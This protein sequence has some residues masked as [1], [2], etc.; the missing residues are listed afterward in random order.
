MNRS[1]EWRRES[2]GPFYLLQH[3][4]NR[5]LEEYLQP[6]RSRGKEAPPTD[7]DPT[8]WN[9]LIDVYETPEEI[10][11]V[12]EI[13]GVNPAAVD[14]AVTGNVMTLRGVKETADLPEPAV[15][16]RERRL[17]SFN[18][19]ITLP[20]QVDFDRAHAEANHGVLKVRLPKRTAAKPRTIPIRPG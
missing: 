18:R 2:S 12:A 19:Q 6:A 15:L 16:L 14:L 4:L 1:S 11:V 9:P 20:D 7:I 8:S 5:L 13:P 10:V 3:E 17:G